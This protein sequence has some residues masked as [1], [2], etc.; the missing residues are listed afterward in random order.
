[1]NIDP[2]LAVL[3]VAGTGFLGGVG[4]WFHQQRSGKL[5]LTGT[6]LQYINEQ[7][8]DIAVLRTELDLMRADFEDL[9]RWALDATHK[10]A[11]TVDL[12]DLPRRRPRTA[13][14]PE[15]KGTP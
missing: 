5:N 13:P 4:T 2:Q 12:G 15:Q 8:A 3:V 14:Q 1:M 6:H 10:A 11:G 7:Q 9:W